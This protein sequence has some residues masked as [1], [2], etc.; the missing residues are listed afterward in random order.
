MDFN[1]T[2]EEA[3]FRARVRAWLGENAKLRDPGAAARG[4]IDEGEGEDL[5]AKART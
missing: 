2:P 5:I 3:E 1:D 4:L